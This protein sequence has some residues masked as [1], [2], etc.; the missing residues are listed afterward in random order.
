MITAATSELLPAAELAA[1][2]RAVGEN[3][4]A[5]DTAGI[6]VTAMRYRALVVTGLLCGIAGTYAGQCA[7]RARPPGGFTPD[8]GQR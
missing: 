6:S 2:L 1:R 3:P 4:S 5:V 7:R 8:R